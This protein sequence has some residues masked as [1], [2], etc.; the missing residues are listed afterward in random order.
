MGAQKS[1]DVVIHAAFSVSTIS[2]H[3][4]FRGLGSLGSTFALGGSEGG[5][6]EI[7]HL[8]FLFSF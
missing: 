4:C 6:S 3:G 1:L 7:F 8:A 5:T 2:G